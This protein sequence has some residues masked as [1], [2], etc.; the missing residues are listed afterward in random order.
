MKKRIRRIKSIKNE[1]ITKSAEAMSSAVQIYNTPN[2]QFKS[3][4][5]IVLAIISWTYLLHAYYR[6]VNVDYR[7]YEVKGKRKRFDKTKYGADKYWVL[8]TCLNNEK[9][10]LDKNI[11]NNLFFLL[12]LRHEIEHRMTTKI[13]D[14]I[15]AKFQACC[16]NY[17]LTL[18]K[19]FPGGKRNDHFQPVALQFSTLAVPQVEQ[20]RRYTELPQNIATFI[21]NFEHDLTEEEFKHHSFS[22]RLKFTRVDAKRDGRADT[23]IRFLSPDSPEAEGIDPELYV[24]IDREKPKFT[25]TAIV[26]KMQNLGYLKFRIY[27][28]TQYW[29]SVDGQNPKKGF[30]VVVAGRW[31][32]YENWIDN[33]KEY[34]QQNEERFK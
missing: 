24:K 9:C 7:Y 14:F 17:F 1:L 33:V 19:L 26:R 27:E 22:Q 16:V 6:R 30:G 2:I 28:H 15:S 3:E 31:L 4:T 13:D 20:L 34:C 25:P 23:V 18:D 29:K 8:E 10:P 5:F 11:K 21:D 12:Q 32:W